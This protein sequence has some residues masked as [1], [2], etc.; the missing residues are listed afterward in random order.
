MS[1]KI[2]SLSYPT[3][4]SY[5]GRANLCALLE[6]EPNSLSWVMENFIQTESLYQHDK[7]NFDVDF[8][9]IP[10]INY[11]S[12]TAVEPQMALCPLISY[13]A[14]KRW[15][16]KKHYKD[17][18]KCIKEWLNNEYCV[19]LIGDIFYI[20]CYKS[21]KHFA[22]QMLVFGYDDINQIFHIADFFEN[23]KYMFSTCTYS[24]LEEAICSIDRMTSDDPA[25]KYLSY[26]VEDMTDV[27][28]IK[29][30]DNYENKFD[31]ERVKITLVDYLGDTNLCETIY[32][33]TNR[34]HT[35]ENNERVFGIKHYDNMIQYLQQC[36][37]INKVAYN[38]RAFHVVSDHKVALLHRIKYLLQN[39]YL[40]DWQMLTYFENVSS[41]C[42]QI[43]NKII[44]DSVT[45]QVTK[46]SKIIDDIIGV[47]EL[48]TQLLRNILCNI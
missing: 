35:N 37:E 19:N 8:F 32:R 4:T 28:F 48:E 12:H 23:W 20:P 16:I 25:L 33:C 11:I 31:I 13:N 27:F 40:N 45:N 44:K 14:L 7:E 1:S 46:C 43:R 36:E 26:F 39:E 41:I 30:N 34:W 21:Q 24:E 5:P 42:T 22:H 17:Y 10:Q 47:K 9:N 29:K 3:I 38:F 15:Y 6:G 2:I 18:T